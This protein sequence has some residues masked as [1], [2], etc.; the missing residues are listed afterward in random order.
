MRVTT[1]LT[2]RVIACAEDLERF[3]ALP[4][5]C[6][7]EAAEFF[8]EHGTKVAID[9]QRR[10]GSSLSYTFSGELTPVQQEAAR[11][12]LAHDAGVFVGPPGIGK[13]GRSGL[14]PIGPSCWDDE[15]GTKGQE[16]DPISAR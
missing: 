9:D 16:Y 10:D 15:A 4:R 2:P 5:G 12:L 3:I 14:R 6:V 11:A 13:M 1:A 7:D 8:R